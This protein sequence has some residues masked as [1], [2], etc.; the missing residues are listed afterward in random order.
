[1]CYVI[2]DEYFYEYPNIF[3]F[4]RMPCKI[5]YKLRWLTN[6]APMAAQLTALIGHG[7]VYR[8]EKSLPAFIGTGF[9][10]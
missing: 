7:L 9:K 2:C 3:R 6:D 8:R 5:V 4:C 1:M 10:K